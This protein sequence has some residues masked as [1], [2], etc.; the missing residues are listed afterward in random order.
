MLNDD[1]SD[2]RVAIAEPLTEL[3]LTVFRLNGMML[4]WGDKLVGPLGLTSAKWQ[5][6]GSLALAE[7]LLTAPQVGQVMG[8]TRQGAQKQLN[9]LEELNLVKPQG[10]PAHK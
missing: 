5:M 1:T 8:V 7:N 6:L 2:G 9:I 10:N 4:Q 3:T